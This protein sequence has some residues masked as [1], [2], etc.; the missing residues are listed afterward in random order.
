MGARIVVPPGATGR[1]GSDLSGK[2]RAALDAIAGGARR[3]VVHVGCADEAAHRRDSALKRAELA[4]ADRELVA[5]LL[6]AVQSLGGRFAVGPDH[7]CDPA[8]GQHTGGP[9]P[10]FGWSPA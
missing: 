1:P 3:V 2:R 10:W 7:G 8:T 9:V 4:R 6:E 5:P